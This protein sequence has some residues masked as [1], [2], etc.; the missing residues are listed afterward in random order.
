MSGFCDR[1]NEKTS[2]LINIGNLSEMASATKLG[3]RHICAP[4][5]DDLLA[6]AGNA[7]DPE[8]DRRA[9]PRVTV[10]MKARVEGNTSHMDQFSEEM[11]IEEISPSG[12]RL[13]TVLQVDTG[14]ILKVAVPSY[15]FEANAI[16]EV[17]WR[18][19]GQRRL[20]LKLIEPSDTWDRLWKDKSSA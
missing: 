14:S 20:G 9:E 11:T 7:G 15:N 10:S 17:V 13:R 1:C 3:Y 4:C 6:E 5:Y 16:V 18:D 2:H 8:E 12:L 19:E